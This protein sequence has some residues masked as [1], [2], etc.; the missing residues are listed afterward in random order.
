MNKASG[1]IAVMICILGMV[2]SFAYHTRTNLNLI[3][4][5]KAPVHV[6]IETDKNYAQFISI[7]ATLNSGET[8]FKLESTTAYSETMKM[9]VLHTG[10]E[11]AAG[12]PHY[13]YNISLRVPQEY[14]R[15]TLMAIEG[16]SIFI[17]NKLFYFSN[18]DIRALNG[19]SQDGYM[20]HLL[21]DLH[22]EKSFMSGWINWYGDLNFI[23]KAGGALFCYP[24]KYLLTWFFVVCLFF[25]C[26]SVLIKKYQ[27]VYNRNNHLPEI[28]LLAAITL[29]GFLLRINGYTHG[30]AWLDELYSAGI[31]SNP[32]QSFLNT[33]GDPGN[34]PFYFICLRLWF[35]LFGWSEQSGR[36]LSVL[37]GTAAIISM[38]LFV[39]SCSGKK[40]AFLSALFMATNTYLIGFAQE[41][42][43]YIIEVFL[44]SII[45]FRFLIF[46]RSQTVKN[47]VWYIIPCILIVNTHY[48]GVFV[49]IAN[50]LYFLFNAYGYKNLTWKKTVSFL[51]GN[52]I[53]A[54]SLLPFFVHTALQQALLD[55]DFNTWIQKPG[56]VFILLAVLIPLFLFLYC[57]VR[58][59]IFRQYINGQQ[60]YLLDYTVFSVCTVFIMAFLISWLRPILVEKY[61]IVC[62]PFLFAILS[63]L[64]TGSYNNT[65]LKFV[66]A[67]G[68]IFIYSIM[69]TGYE[70]NLGGG[71]DVYKESQAYIIRDAKTNAER[72]SAELFYL[73]HNKEDKFV[74]RYEYNDNEKK[75]LLQYSY[76][77]DFYGYN[78]LPYYTPNNQYA[79]L[80]VNPLHFATESD[81]YQ[82]MARRGISD[83]NTVRIKVNESK[84]ILKKYLR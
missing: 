25:L 74:M 43:G 51:L 78:Q 9:V 48:Y 61:L 73:W 35:M 50:F 2:L 3:G 70:E 65:S 42:R 67:I 23:I 1:K 75:S 81:M 16:I 69:L 6:N 37:I 36:F 54:L 72:E 4:K 45:A 83:E 19:R 7:T 39:K 5:I 56:M 21:P 22:Y 53:I 62:F 26:K 60:Y 31:A 47:M 71:I 8:L 66:M 77:A 68:G 27:A 34:P 12:I 84:T 15:E 24:G 59:S 17:G 33:F 63:V 57:H 49:V 11:N 80:Y 44:V 41:M 52:I 10:F 46:V 40:A 79:I 55:Q 32:H 14:D 82:E 58:R 29:V 28:V 30:S 20:L 18:A 13:I 64:L 76:Y 38:Y